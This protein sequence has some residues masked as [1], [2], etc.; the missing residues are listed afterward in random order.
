MSKNYIELVAPF[1]SAAHRSDC[2]I[3]HANK[4]PRVKSGNFVVLPISLPAF[5]STSS[6]HQEGRACDARDHSFAYNT[7][8]EN[9]VIGS[10]CYFT[11]FYLPHTEIASLITIYFEV[12]LY[13]FFLLL[14]MSERSY[15]TVTP[16]ERN[17]ER[18]SSLQLGEGK[19]IK[20]QNCW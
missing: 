18:L 16:H 10:R 7:N 19:E 5:C 20:K 3:S 12:F 4:Q 9:V 8:L 6:C 2:K 11:P 15:A 14:M 1:V 13:F 17:K